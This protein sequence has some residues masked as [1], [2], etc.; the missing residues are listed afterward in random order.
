MLVQPL[1]STTYLYL[2]SPPAFGDLN[3][4]HYI[5]RLKKSCIIGP[6]WQLRWT[7]EESLGFQNYLSKSGLMASVWTVQITLVGKWYLW[8][9]RCSETS[10]VW[11]PIY[12]HFVFF[13]HPL[14]VVSEENKSEQLL[15]GRDLDINVF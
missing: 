14:P 12:L 2:L 7:T 3:P 11:W 10:V 6:V 1:F 5:D 9:I 4:L 8:H 13:S 15:I